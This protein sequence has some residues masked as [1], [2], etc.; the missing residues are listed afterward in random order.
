MNDVVKPGSPDLADADYRDVFLA[1]PNPYL[2]LRADAPRFTIAAVNAAYLEATATDRAAMIG[3]GLFEIFPDDP[4]DGAATGVS[5]LRASLDRVIRDRAPDGMGV[6]KYD[7]PVRDGSGRFT[8]KYWSPVNTPVLSADNRI[9]FIIHRVEDVTEFIL[10]RERSQ[11]ELARRIETVSAKA[12]V[13]EAEVM[14]GGAQIKEANRDLKLSLERLGEANEQL[15]DEDRIKT[16]QLDLAVNAAR[17]GTWTLDVK[18][19]AIVT[20]DLCRRDYGWAPDNPFTYDDLLG[21]IHPDDRA[22]RDRLV[23]HAFA[24]GEDLDIEYRIIKPDGDMAWILVRGR[25]QFDASGVPF[26]ATG[27]SLDVTERKLAETRKNALI[28]ELNHRVKNTLAMVQSIALQTG[29]GVQ[30]PTDFMQ[31][32]DG[33][34]QALVSAHDLLTANS[35]SGAKLDDV[36]RRTVGPHAAGRITIDGPPVQLKAEP[37]V[38]LHM[39]FH[40]LTTNA[41]KYGALSTPDGAISI[42][43]TIDRTASPPLIHITWA[44]HGGPP[45]TPPSRRGFGSN[46]LQTGLPREFGGEAR[47]SFAREG[48]ICDMRFPNSDKMAIA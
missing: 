4:A 30:S 29:I 48:L 47:L 13:M 38:T 34:I 44:E 16:E 20:S 23:T 42:S 10:S 6:Q 37:A 46:L 2:L 26:R 14:R 1:A 18:T 21:L 3:H 11:A 35:W 33:R 25:A 36:I 28:S 43:W 5:D 40:E 15:R 12:D 7:I 27:V 22:R 41:L 19:R 32:F 8:V 39:A 45:V 17:L 31:A 24:T 9:T